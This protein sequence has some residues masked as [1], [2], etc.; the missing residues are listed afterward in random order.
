MSGAPMPSLTTGGRTACRC[1]LW[2]CGLEDLRMV[3]RR[4]SAPDAA[5]QIHHQDLSVHLPPAQ[6]DAAQQCRFSGEAFPKP[7]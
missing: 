7:G 6:A 5:P 3:C 4:Q 1:W 2:L